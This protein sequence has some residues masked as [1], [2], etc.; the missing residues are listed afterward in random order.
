MSKVKKAILL[1][2]VGG[3]VLML[4]VIL[5]AS[6]LTRYLIEKYDVELTGR[7][8]TMKSAYA[9]PFTGYVRLN[10]LVI[11]EA[12]SEEVFI[13]AQSLALNISLL[14]LLF[15]TYEFTEATLISPRG[16]VLERDKIFNFTDIIEK[17]TA[18]DSTVLRDVPV[19]F[20]MHNIRVIDGEFHYEELESDVN[21]FIKD[22]NIHSPGFS[23]DVDTMPFSF[24]FSSG[25]GTG[26]ING[27]WTINLNNL[28]YRL[29][30]NIDSLNLEII[31]QYLRELTNYGTFAAVLDAQ[32]QTSGNFGNVQAMNSSGLLSINDFH[33]GKSPEEDYASFENL[34]IAIIEMNPEGLIYHYDSV[35]LVKP[36]FRY[37]LYDH[38]DNVQTMFGIDGS[39]V[40][41][42]SASAQQF[43]LVLEIARMVQELSRNFF[44]SHYKVGHVAIYDG[45]FEFVDYSLSEEFFISLYP[46]NARADSVDKSRDRIHVFGSSGLK[47]YGEMEVS[48]SVNPQDTSYFDLDYRIHK[49]PLSMFNPYVLTYTS[50]PLDRGVMEITG[51]WNVNAGEISSENHLIMLDPRVARKV[52]SA[53]NRWIPLPLAMAFIRENG[54]VIDYEIPIAG[55][56]KDPKFKI[57]D[58]LLD[59]LKNIFIKPVTTPYRMKVKNVEQQMEKSLAMTWDI[60][61]S[62]LSKA[63]EKFVSKMVSFL[64][65]NPEARI[66]ISPIYHSS[67]E[68]EFILLYEAKKR[69]LISKGELSKSV[70]SEADSIRVVRM[71][72]KDEGFVKYLNKHS[73]D[74]N[75]FA[76]QR[77]ANSVVSRAEVDRAFNDLNARRQVVF[78]APFE[79]HKV[80]DRISFAKAKS[81][82][83]FSGFSHYDIFYE[84]EFPDYLRE[85][86]EQM[87]VMDSENPREKYQ[88]KRIRNTSR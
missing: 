60:H 31:N 32:I 34:T 30:F 22:V 37:E 85:A 64:K 7:E 69:Y 5:C 41:E 12:N 54:N 4:V 39:N 72:I 17:F 36:F 59:L 50:F 53:D 44:R 10:D 33:F 16:N 21:Y 47:P 9:N 8:I 19:K 56:M 40:V 25:I 67:R 28:D 52:K 76:T 14:K 18:I 51:K 55:N 26:H 68:K 13:Q 20:R 71:S 84:G 24:D 2:V 63:Q 48:L 66:R 79:N 46:F 73:N 23:Y 15:S 87:N 82:V 81:I 57:R 70:F 83:P 75:L 35:S 74:P 3:I 29:A 61:E 38:L 1:S 80:A 88:I 49:I 42:A 77:K 11:H 86:F 27:D 65:K 45:N 6:P 78:L 58:V 43:N 62:N